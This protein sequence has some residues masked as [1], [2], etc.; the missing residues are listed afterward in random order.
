MARVI[1][2]RAVINRKGQP[3]NFDNTI[4]TVGM[5]FNHALI[6]ASV[7]AKN[8]DIGDISFA[9]ARIDAGNG[10]LGRRMISSRSPS[11]R[12]SSRKSRL[13]SSHHINAQMGDC[14]RNR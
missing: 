10:V 6:S 8:C 14:N 11:G 13:K 9:G 3:P 12:K 1:F 7:F 2:R 4:I 5:K